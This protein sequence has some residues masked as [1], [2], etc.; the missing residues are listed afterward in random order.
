[1]GNVSK[2]WNWRRK[3]A[4]EGLQIWRLTG[5]KL[6]GPN[7]GSAAHYQTRKIY[8]VISHSV[9]QLQAKKIVLIAREQI[10][11]HAMLKEPRILAMM[12]NTLFQTI[13][14]R[15]THDYVATT[16]M[17]MMIILFYYDDENV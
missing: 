8:Q 4:I 5:F 11:Q 17:M 9:F 2:F 10:C 7:I 12:I 1:M 15:K 13:W 14:K 16:L 6:W 3:A